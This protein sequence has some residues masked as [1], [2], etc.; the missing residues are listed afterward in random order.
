L[1]IERK[2]KFGI[3]GCG[4]IS[5]VPFEAFKNLKEEVMIEAITN[6]NKKR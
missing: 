1:V 6:I 2:I 4:R 3:I 5:H